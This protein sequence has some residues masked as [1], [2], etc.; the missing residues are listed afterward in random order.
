MK[1]RWLYFTLRCLGPLCLATLFAAATSAGAQQSQ[2]GYRIAGVV[3]DS[4]TGAPVPHA[5]VSVFQD[6]EETQST[7]GEDGRFI[8]SGLAA[9]KYPLSATAHGYVREGYQQ[10]GAYTTGIAVGDGLDSEHLVFRLHR[11][12]VITG[13]VTDEYGEPLR[14]AQIILLRFESGTGSGTPSDRGRTA[15][16]DLGEYRFPHL[17]PGKYYV[18]VSARPWYAQMELNSATNSAQSGSSANGPSSK[19]NVNPLLDV[20]YPVTFSPNATEGRTAEELTLAAGETKQADIHVQAVPAVHLRLT[21][22]STDENAQ[23]NFSASESLFGSLDEAV[24]TVSGQIS[25]GEY[26]VAG[27][28]PGD[29]ALE[30]IENGSQSRSSRTIRTNLRGSD[31]L[32]VA[33]SGATANVTG[34]VILHDQDE[35][36]E[37]GQVSLRNENNQNAS[38]ALQKDGTFSL[39]SVQS[40]TYKIFVNFP[41][42]EDFIEKLSATGA[43]THGREVTISGAGDVQ[44]LI[45][46]GQAEGELTGVAKLDGKLTSGVMVLLVPETGENLEENSHLDESDSDGTFTLAEIPPGKYKLMAIEDGWELERTNWSALQPYLEKGQPLDFSASEKKKV[47]VQV[48]RLKK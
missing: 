23:I 21:N 41:D 44:L 16:D 29:I 22:L 18:A 14:Q 35:S 8:F 31:S 1:P 37:Q 11:Q 47:V 17:L 2:R 27:L 13:R 28:P 4:A 39:S 42:G 38:T 25:P 20:V 6:A 5:T 33:G 32:E 19:P 48:Q 3:V 46:A 15:T 43:T 30:V 10:H 12:A 40:D 7:S 34:R 36:P 45:T 24:N 9:A 26:E